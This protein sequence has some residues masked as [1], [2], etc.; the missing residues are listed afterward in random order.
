MVK[1]TNFHL[2][3]S[4]RAKYDYFKPFDDEYQFTLKYIKKKIGNGVVSPKSI[5]NEMSDVHNNVFENGC[6]GVFTVQP[7]GIL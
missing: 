2:T 3:F 1:S 5:L 4:A 7:V 6:T